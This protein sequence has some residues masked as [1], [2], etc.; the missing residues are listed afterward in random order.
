MLRS[1]RRR[2]IVWDSGDLSD[3]LEK[4]MWQRAIGLQ[5]ERWPDIGPSK[6]EGALLVL[7]PKAQ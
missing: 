4:D 2:E 6:D 5:T 3:F 1:Q 7:R